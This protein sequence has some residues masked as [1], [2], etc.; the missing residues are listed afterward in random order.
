MGCLAV[1]W[2]CQ[3]LSCLTDFSCDLLAMWNVHV[4]ENCIF[5][6]LIFFRFFFL[7]CYF[8]V[9]PSPITLQPFH[10]S[11]P[12]STLVFVTF[13]LTHLLI[14]CISCLLYKIFFVTVKISW[15]IFIWLYHV[16]LSLLRTWY[17]AHSGFLINIEWM[18]DT[19]LEQTLVR[20]WRPILFV[21]IY[22][23]VLFYFIF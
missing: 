5:W 7:K 8:L 21:F 4:P 12:L 15:G 9:I 18:N 13:L 1:L 11:Y 3:I 6:S 19:V 14:N 2:T 17:L 20:G 10:I 23:F 22:L 16:K